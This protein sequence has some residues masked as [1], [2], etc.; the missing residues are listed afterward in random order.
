MANGGMSAWVSEGSWFAKARALLAERI[1]PSLLERASRLGVLLFFIGLFVLHA[2]MLR[3]LLQNG[4]SAVY[5]QQIETRDLSHR[6]THVGYFA[7][8]VA[9]NELLPFGTDLNMN[10]MVLTVG[11][12]GLAAVYSTTKLLS[13]SRWAALGSVLL[14]LGLTAE[15]RGMLLS[16]VDGVS[17]AFVAVAF[18][19]F[20]RG[21][22]L[23]AGLLFGFAVLVTPLSGPLVVL[24]LLTGG[25]SPTGNV[26]VLRYRMRSLFKF[27]AGALLVFAP[28]VLIHYQDYV[29]GP[30]GLVNAPRAALSVS[31]RI[32]HS[33]HF[34][35][36][37]LGLMLPLYV[38]GVFLCLAS[39][40][41]KRA[42]Q[43]ALALLISIGLM[44][45]VGERF[46]DVHVQLP[47]LV[48]FGILQA[49]AFASS[50]RAVRIGLFALFAV[51]L[52]N[53]RTSYANVLS[54]IRA[55]AKDR[56]LCLAIRAQSGPRAPV[57][58][59]L[60]GF[61]Q[62]RIFER[63]TS[64]PHQPALALDWSSFIRHQERWLDPAE[65]TRIWFFRRVQPGKVAGLLTLYSLESRRIEGRRLQVLVPFPVPV[66]P[67]AGP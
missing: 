11:L 2:S 43:P 19:C 30:R 21:A 59:A 10:V 17:V 23:A 13:E 52:L 31:E 15:I 57:L 24:F 8:G 61:S 49:V 45:A 44:A 47:N 22:S 46:L 5:N 9:F 55:R 41:S 1:S 27:G 54:D 29:F 62:S 20:Q 6:T 42:R 4:D 64:G 48:L 14:A 35:A 63:F 56:A 58:V 67:Q 33:W 40:K 12:L 53:T 37:Q 65:Q 3:P 39:P 18:A 32:A 36:K 7:L 25:T 60:S 38:A 26:G 66:P 34:I 50:G 16:E 28:P 51:G